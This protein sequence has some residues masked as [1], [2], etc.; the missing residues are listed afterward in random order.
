MKKVFHKLI[1]STVAVILTLLGLEA[2]FRLFD[3]RGYHAPR[4]SLWRSALMSPK[5]RLP[6]VHVQFRPGS[7]F[8]LVYDSNPRGYFDEE[9]G[10]LCTVNKWGFR[11]PDFEM[12]RKE[13]AKRIM[14]LGDSFTFGEGVR[15]EDT[16]VN[17]L[18]RILN[19]TS[20]KPVEVLNF[21]TSA[22]ASRDEANYLEQVGVKFKPDLI[23]IGYVLNDGEH[24]AG[25]HVWNNFRKEYDA[26]A[27]QTSYLL[28][29]VYATAKRLINGR[30]YVAE[31]ADS[32]VSKPE[33]AKWETSF[34]Y[35]SKVKKIADL[36]GARFAVVIFPFM[37]EL[38]DG[39]PFLKIHQMIAEHCRQNGIEVLDLLDAYKGQYFFDLW[40]HQSDQHPNE[41]GHKIAASA[42]AEFIQEKKLLS[43]TSIPSAS[44]ANVPSVFSQ[45]LRL[46]NP[47]DYS[48][49][50][51]YVW[52]NFQQETYL[53]DTASKR[54]KTYDVSWRIAPPTV[55][56]EGP[57]VK[58]LS[59][60][61]SF[62][63]IQYL[64]VSVA[65]SDNPT[66]DRTKAVYERRYLYTLTDD[67]KIVAVTPPGEWYTPH[68]GKSPWIKDDI[69]AVMTDR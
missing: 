32:I 50:F 30:R 45:R 39:Y 2:A 4:R 19:E 41:K 47:T 6:G 29:F 62:S 46:T 5:E 44:S 59:T 60:L 20:E 56:Y 8:K 13:N 65:F 28:S 53:L 15:L 66:F 69:D 22:W 36:K 12:A 54:G 14:V 18:E 51:A 42:I 63:P 10:I 9:N 68:I 25:L 38:N 52:N 55:E 23:L 57:V 16:Y 48:Y 64:A 40:T 31:M 11:G 3:I 27:Y 34:S 24:D 37:Y 58:K 21:G 61:R 49:V 35:L 26:Q 43:D 33:R 67:N 17:R 7:K 1:L